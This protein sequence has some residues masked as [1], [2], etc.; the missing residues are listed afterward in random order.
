[1]GHFS[2]PFQHFASCSNTRYEW[3]RTGPISFV[4]SGQK[5][6]RRYDPFV[7]NLVFV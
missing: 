7:C 4:D 5:G 3:G 1:M 6:P 2:R